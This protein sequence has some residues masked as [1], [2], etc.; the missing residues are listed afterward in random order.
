MGDFGWPEDESVVKRRVVCGVKTNDRFNLG[1]ILGDNVYLEGT[2]ID[3]YDRLDRVFAQSFPATT[4]PFDF[5]AILGNHD[6]MG[7]VYTQSLYHLIREPRQ[8][9]YVF[10]LLH[11]HINDGCGPHRYVPHGNPLIEWIRQ[12]RAT[13]VINGHNHNMQ[14]ISDERRQR[15]I[16]A[17]QNGSTAKNVAEYETLLSSTIQNIIKK[18]SET[19]RIFIENRGGQLVDEN[20]GLSLKQIYQNVATRFDITLS[21]TE[22]NN[23]FGQK[24]SSLK[25]IHIIPNRINDPNTICKRNPF[26]HSF[27]RIEENYPNEQ[28]Y[29]VDEGR[30]S[31]GTPSILRVPNIRSRNVSVFCAMNRYGVVH[32]GI[33]SRPYNFEAFLRRFLKRNLW[34]VK[35][36]PEGC[37]LT[38]HV[39]FCPHNSELRFQEIRSLRILG[40]TTGARERITCSRP[41]VFNQVI[42]L[43]YTTEMQAR[44]RVDCAKSSMLPKPLLLA[45]Q[46]GGS[47]RLQLCCDDSG[48]SSYTFRVKSAESP[49]ADGSTSYST[50]K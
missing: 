1:L 7:D 18:Y 46:V 47:S 39:Y 21:K 17:H 3:D 12:S 42:G 25:A 19:G 26:A 5:L 22:I 48:S 23:Y 11:H 13:A 43:I 28:I 44:S 4:F 30:S 9:D 6:H 27:L 37:P 32:K 50:V 20:C 45:S 24:H 33:N 29:F 14:K 40:H 8:Y 31:I 34:A 41:A 15:I 10:I 36:K 16:N 35:P 2:Q 38:I 49:G